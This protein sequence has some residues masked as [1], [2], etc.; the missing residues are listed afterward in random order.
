MP[1]ALVNSM[2]QLF[3]NGR[4]MFRAGVLEKDRHV[5]DHR[6]MFRCCSFD[7]GG[8]LIAGRI[9]KGLKKVKGPKKMENETLCSIA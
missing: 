1:N 8:S 2:S 9:I 3:Q 4:N 7:S 6:G 5:E